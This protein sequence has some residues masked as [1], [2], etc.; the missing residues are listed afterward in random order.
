MNKAVKIILAI[1]I[2]IIYPLFA[3]L[4]AITIYPNANTAKST[5]SVPHYPN[6]EECDILPSQTSI[7]NSFASSNQSRQSR[8]ACIAVKEADFDQKMS[9]YDASLE[10]HTSDNSAVIA[11]RIKV[12]LV[13]VILGFVLTMLASKISPIAAGVAMGSTV[14]LIGATGFA[15]AAIGNINFSVALLYLVLF[16]EL[17][18][19]MFVIDRVFKPVVSAKTE[20]KHSRPTQN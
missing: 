4:L 2:A 15:V 11:N 6:T 9:A 1:S 7:D 3:F 14:L 16:V 17:N 8:D 18:I 12:V 10:A 19:I 20:S 5:T 13:F